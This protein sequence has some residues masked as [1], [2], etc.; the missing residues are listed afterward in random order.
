MAVKIARWFLVTILFVSMEH[1]GFCSTGDSVIVKLAFQRGEITQASDLKMTL[2]INSCAR[3]TVY[4]PA[5][6]LWGVP[7]TVG[8]FY[9]ILV[10]KKSGK[11]YNNLKIFGALN[12]LPSFD[13]DRLHFGE[14]KELAFGLNMLYQFT[15]GEY[16]VR[17]LCKFSTLNKFRDKY[18]NWAYFKCLNDIAIK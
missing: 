13:N 17:V 10:Q 1:A 15:K 7:S 8:V 9:I 6:D 18:S 5:L 3:Q 16:R 12:N 11:Y 14:K 2:T 4:V